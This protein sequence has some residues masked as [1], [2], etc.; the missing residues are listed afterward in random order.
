MKYST[1]FGIDSHSRTTTI[2]ALVPETGEFEKR[3]FR[4]NPYPTMREWMSRFPTPARG[5]YES[6]RTGFVPAR[7][8]SAEGV[9]V[10]P[11]ATSKMPS[12]D[13]TRKRKN[14]RRDSR[15][16]AERSDSNLLEDACVHTQRRRASAT[17]PTPSRT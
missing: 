6:G 12:A 9:D 2:C 8:L 1:F 14:D 3:T 7:E 13:D 11:T 15:Q 17:S 16:L 5:V 10:V 4:D